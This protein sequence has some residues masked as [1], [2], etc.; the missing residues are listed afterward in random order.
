MEGLGRGHHYV[1]GWVCLSSP[2]EEGGGG[3]NHK[4][5]AY[6]VCLGFLTI[7]VSFGVALEVLILKNAV[8]FVLI[9]ILH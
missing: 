2:L 7:K 9:N 4:C 5:L 6:L 1:K 3:V 8:V